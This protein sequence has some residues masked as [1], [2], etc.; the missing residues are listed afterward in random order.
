MGIE[1]VLER[2]PEGLRVSY[3]TV[4]LGLAYMPQSK[5]DSV[6]EPGYGEHGKL[7]E[8]VVA[9][10]RLLAAELISSYSLE[11]ERIATTLSHQQAIVLQLLHYVYAC[12]IIRGRKNGK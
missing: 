3:E 12:G 11:P 2:I 6:I 8:A 9:Q 7:I 10:H 5:A 1:E 4:N